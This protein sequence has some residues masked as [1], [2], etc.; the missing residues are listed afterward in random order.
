MFSS[1]LLQT[2]F[3]HIFQILGLRVKV[4]KV[5]FNNI[6]VILR[7]SVLLVVVETGVLG[8][9]SLTNFIT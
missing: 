9:K 3:V 7:S 1:N 5:T 8:E 4:F 6:S 2:A